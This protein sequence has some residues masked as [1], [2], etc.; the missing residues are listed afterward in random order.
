MT[1]QFAPELA[2]ARRFLASRPPPGDVL[3]CALTGAHLYGF[4]SADSDLDLKGAHISPTAPLLGLAPETPA[5]DL[6]V[7]FEGVECDLTTQEVGRSLRL[8]LVGNGNTLEQL[9]SPHQVLH[10]PELEELRALAPAVFSTLSAR[11]YRGFLRGLQRDFDRAEH[12]EVKTLLYAHRVAGTG[13]HLLL[14]GHVLSH[15][16]TLNDAHHL[17]AVDELI[18]RKRGGGEHT[19]LTAAE[20]RQRAPIFQN[21]DQRLGDAFDRSRLPAEPPSAAALESWLIRARRA[22]L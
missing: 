20:K 16:P 12:P 6:T 13:I 3:F 11:H 17:G 18:A 8:L 9:Y 15:L 5:F 19:R 4:P 22:R 7:E 14:T 21:L 2:L 10:T 1:E